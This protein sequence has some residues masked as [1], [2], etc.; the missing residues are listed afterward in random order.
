LT[1]RGYKQPKATA[2][3]ERR[4]KIAEGIERS[5]TERCPMVNVKGDSPP[6]AEPDEQAPSTP[7]GGA[8]Q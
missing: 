4:A 8:S 3:D 7:L 1:A 2:R 5:I 6:A